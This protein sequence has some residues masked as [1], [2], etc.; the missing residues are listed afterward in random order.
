ML[1][2]L[3]LAGVVGVCGLAYAFF[4]AYSH[5]AEVGGLFAR[6]VQAKAAEAKRR[7]WIG[8]SVAVDMW[9]AF[10]Y[11]A[12]D[13]SRAAFGR[14][15]PYMR[16]RTNIVQVLQFAGI[17]LAAPLSAQD[18]ELWSTRLWLFVSALLFVAGIL[19]RGP[20]DAPAGGPGAEYERQQ[21][22]APQ[23]AMPRT[24]GA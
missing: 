19:Y 15:I 23:A 1:D 18:L 24:F 11:H 6:R 21:S 7:F 17:A 16:S 13:F 22:F 9:E 2:S 5:S 14:I 10:A 20:K 4:V 3:A 12:R 8:A